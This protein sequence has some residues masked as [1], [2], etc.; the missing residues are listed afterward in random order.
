MG[1]G[2]Q[3]VELDRCLGNV[4]S[5]GNVGHMRHDQLPLP[6]D[7]PTVV[8]TRYG[9]VDV[10][11]VVREVIVV[12]GKVL[13]DDSPG[14]SNDIS[15]AGSIQIVA[16]NPNKPNQY[17][18]TTLPLEE[19]LLTNA[20]M[21]HINDPQPEY[22]ALSPGKHLAAVS[23]QE[24]NGI[25]IVDPVAAEIVGAFNLGTV[26]DRPADLLDDDEVRQ[27][28]A[29]A[30]KYGNKPTGSG[31]RPMKVGTLSGDA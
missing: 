4:G 6:G 15:N 26:S 25:V 16:I 10:D 8:Q 1:I 28:V 3:V 11:G 30:Y 14:N 21:L 18:V 23:L 5:P 9:P 27:A 12:D 24:N 20:L 29:N 13:D 2:R 22:V 17:S 7:A 31:Y 19:S